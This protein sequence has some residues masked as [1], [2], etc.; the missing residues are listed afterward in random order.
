MAYDSHNEIPTWEQRLKFWR[1]LGV[2]VEMLPLFEQIN[3]WWD[4]VQ[5][6]FLVASS[7][8]DKADGFSDV[9][10]LMLYCFSWVQ[11]VDA[12][13][14]WGREMRAYVDPQRLRWSG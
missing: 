4:P 11:F 1:P 12:R 10:A 8:Q 2:D 14:G 6:R 3:P 7:L 9:E 5:K 13:F